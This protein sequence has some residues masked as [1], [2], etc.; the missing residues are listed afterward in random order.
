MKAT[1]KLFI[2]DW[3]VIY[4][5]LFCMLWV[6]LF[7][8][9][10]TDP[11]VVFL[12]YAGALVFVVIILSLQSSIKYSPVGFIRFWYPLMLVWF[13]Y[14]KATQMDLGDYKGF[15]DPFFQDIDQM[16]FGYQPSLIW[17]VL[18]DSFLLQ[19]LFHFSYFSFYPLFFGLSLY[20]YI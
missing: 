8:N 15:L 18:F 19:E 20:V 4:Y 6:G 9:Y 16:I 11:L 13:F 14:I 5:I 10:I 3:L 2:S 1:R 12:Q 7:R 17:G